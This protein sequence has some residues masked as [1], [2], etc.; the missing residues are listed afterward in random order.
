MPTAR[1]RRVPR[2]FLTAGL[3]ALLTTTGALAVTGQPAS[4]LQNYVQPVEVTWTDNARPTRSFQAEDAALP[5]GSWQ[6][7]TGDKHTSRAY[8]TFDLSPYLGQRIISARAVAGERSV[9]DCDKPRELQLWR[10]E[11]PTTAPTWKSAPA[12]VKKLADLDVP[13]APCPSTYLTT[14]V[15][16]EV[17][18]AIAARQSR[19]TFMLRIGEHEDGLQWGRR[20]NTLG[21]SLEHNHAPNA[22]GKLSA[23][24]LACRDDLFIGTTRPEFRAEV[25]DPDVNETG[26]VDQLKATFAWWPTD[27][28]AERT[29]LEFPYT[30][31][32]GSRFQ[33]TIPDGVMTHGGT[34]AFTVRATDQYGDT[35]DWAPE[36]RFTVDTRIPARPVVTSTDYPA[37][38]YEPTAFGPGIP[39]TFT[40]SPNGSDDVVKYEYT[41]WDSGFGTVP[42][43]GPGGTATVTYTP[44]N[45]GYHRLE[46][47]SIDRTGNHS[48]TTL[49]E[50]YVRQT[51]PRITDGNPTGGFGEPRELTLRP[52]M[53]NV[54]EYSWQLNDGE[55]TTVRADADGTAKVTVTP[56]RGGANM[57]TVTSRTSDDLPSGTGEYYFYLA[58]T[59][60]ISS[61]DFPLDGSDGPLAGTPGTFIFAPGMPGVTEYVWSVGGGA[62]HTV[63]AKEDGTATVSYTPTEAGFQWIEVFSRTADGDESETASGYFVIFSHA[64]EVT[65]SD[66]PAYGES[67]GPGVAG[68]FTFRPARDGVTGYVYDFGDGPKTVT[69]AA[70]GTATIDWTPQSYRVDTQGLVRLKVREKIGDIVSDE[71]E[72]GFYLGK[73]A[74]TVTSQDYPP[75]GEV[76]G[77]GIAGSFTLT[78]HVPGSTEFV[79]RHGTEEK[80]VSAGPDGTATITLTPTEV[81]GN[82]L[83]VSSR[84]DSGITSG[85]GVYYFTVA[86]PN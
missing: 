16:N 81:G 41:S 56:R 74:P 70:D 52:G 12:A 57:V 36:C 23:G 66:Y 24:G 37:A 79:Y 77:P 84:T 85:E 48:Q 47:S 83:Y 49:Y 67:G 53:E 40:F 44:K 72:Y 15:T 45:P 22:P 75:S 2:R 63:A 54:V 82:Y 8:F 26:G 1:R 55:P 69:A 34:Y 6:S 71:T 59:P 42:A 73:L 32:S 10:T 80:T 68:Q 25:T 43:D 30:L 60:T 46:V 13:G 14:L 51:A 17:R 62:Q 58:S 21:V 35:S 27:R 31:P 3:A 7:A 9:N 28:P 20:V 78:A 64:P 86:N 4:A 76:G 29:E 61:P 19:I 65:S 11:N 50:F 38:P 5:V 18:A 33:Y 39:G